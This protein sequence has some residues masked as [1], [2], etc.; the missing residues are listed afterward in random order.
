M[1]ENEKQNG[2]ANGEAEV[3]QGAGKAIDSSNSGL[4]HK[5][6]SSSWKRCDPGYL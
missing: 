4:H 3:K 1:S 2:G 5:V 6:A